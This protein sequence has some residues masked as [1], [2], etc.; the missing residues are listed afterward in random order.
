MAAEVTETEAGATGDT[1]FNA[2][3]SGADTPRLVEK[4]ENRPAAPAPAPGEDAPQSGS[5]PPSE[6]AEGA[7]PRTPTKT[8]GPTQEA[9]TPDNGRKQ[10][11]A[12]V[13]TSTP[14][15]H[16]LPSPTAHNGSLLERQESV[17][18]TEAR[19]RMEGVELK[20][21]WQDED[22]PRPLPEEEEDMQMDEELFTGREGNSATQSYELNSDKKAKKKL[23]APYISLTLDRT[24]GSVLS[25]EMEESGE[26]D[27]DDIDT[28]SDNSNE[29]EWEVNLPE[30]QRQGINACTEIFISKQQSS[31]ITKVVFRIF[32]LSNQVIYFSNHN[33]N[34]LLNFSYIHYMAEDIQEVFR[35]TWDHLVK[36]NL[37]CSMKWLHTVMSVEWWQ[38]EQEKLNWNS[39]C[40]IQVE[41]TVWKFLSFQVLVIKCWVRHTDMPES[42]LSF[43]SSK[44]SQKIKYVFSLVELAELV[45]MEYVSIPECI[46]QYE[47][48]KNRKRRKR[49]DRDMQGKQEPAA[50]ATEQ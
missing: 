37:I 33:V 25:D 30:S 1:G 22:F 5:A 50:P 6:T 35:I 9:G 21:E 27:L 28:P 26:L 11:P 34:K 8:G 15:S 42:I 14:V 13:R 31:V 36:V 17:A 40:I 23:M 19:L 49:I 16:S 24:E 4:V 20:E 45:P 2:S 3:S 12:G 29:F 18:T 10:E 44:F 47:E 41:C 43:H 7:A 48:E 39:K 38:G 32:F 46:K